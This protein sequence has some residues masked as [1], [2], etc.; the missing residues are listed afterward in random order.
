MRYPG[1]PEKRNTSLQAQIGLSSWKQPR[2]QDKDAGAMGLAKEDTV[3]P[4]W[5]PLPKEHIYRLP[6]QKEENWKKTETY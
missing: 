1:C 3:L 6:L 2:L 4:C 5:D